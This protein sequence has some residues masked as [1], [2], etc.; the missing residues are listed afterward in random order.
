MKYSKHRTRWWTLLHNLLQEKGQ[1][2]TIKISIL[3]K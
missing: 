2:I 1:K 3:I